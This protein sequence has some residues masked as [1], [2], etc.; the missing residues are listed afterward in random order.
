M[1]PLFGRAGKK[2]SATVAAV[3]V[4][5][6]DEWCIPSDQELFGTRPSEVTESYA[7]ETV[8]EV[9][10]ESSSTNTTSFQSLNEEEGMFTNITDDTF[11]VM[12]NE[13]TI[14]TSMEELEIIDTNEHIAL[15]TE[16]NVSIANI[17]MDMDMDMNSVLKKLNDLERKFEELNSK[18]TEF[19][20]LRSQKGNNT[21]SNA[22]VFVNEF[23]CMI[24]ELMK[25]GLSYQQ[26]VIGK[27]IDE[28]DGMFDIDLSNFDPFK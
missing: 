4:G 26:G 9:S 24:Q 17:D 16:S 28:L 11:A 13:T 20:K 12:N 25:S 23:V 19:E 5:L 27:F 21:D 18:I 22:T 6:N 2:P 8:I 3:A 15:A 7:L 1:L 14:V 10:N